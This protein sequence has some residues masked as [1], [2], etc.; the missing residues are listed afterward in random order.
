[1]RNTI[2]L[3]KRKRMELMRRANS[4]TGRA[5]DAQRA[6][7]ILLLAEGRTWDVVCE[8]VACSR[9]F[10][11]SWSQRFADARLAGLY[12]RCQ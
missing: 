12:R 8:H 10:V 3:T 11:A 1:M 7:V 4:R 5:E 9:G 2:P 6:R